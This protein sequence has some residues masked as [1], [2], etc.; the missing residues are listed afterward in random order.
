MINLTSL[1]ES[2][3]SAVLL[4]LRIPAEGDAWLGLGAY[5]TQGLSGDP[6]T[7]A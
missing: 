1:E 6:A 7:D 4:L 2:R 3:S 5:L